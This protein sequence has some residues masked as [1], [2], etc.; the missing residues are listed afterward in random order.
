MTDAAEPVPLMR[1]DD[2][3][4]GALFARRFDEMGI[5]AAPALFNTH[6]HSSPAEHAS[7]TLPKTAGLHLIRPGEHLHND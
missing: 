4:I 5:R 1:A 7:N 3:E 6:A 2:D